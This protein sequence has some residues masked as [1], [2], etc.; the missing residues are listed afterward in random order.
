M[1]TIY[2]SKN[3]DSRTADGKIDSTDLTKSTKSHIK[4]VREAMGFIADSLKERSKNHD[5]TKLENIDAFADALNSGHIK[6]TDWYKY[7]VTK[8]RHHL[9]SH[10][11][12]NVNLIDVIEHICDCTMAGLARSGSVFDIDI[13]PDVLTL[14]VQNTVKILINHTEVLDD[15]HE[16]HFGEDDSD[17]L[18]QPVEEE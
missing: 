6:D 1:I 9:K 18:N 2:K 8:E 14:A 5:Y 13:D 17:I 15:N 4:D 11:P 16:D 10:I 12:E 3:A 7:H